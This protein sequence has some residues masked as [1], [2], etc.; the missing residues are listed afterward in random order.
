M[1]ST[2][3]TVLFIAAPAAFLISG[4]ILHFKF[5]KTILDAGSRWSYDRARL[6]EQLREYRDIMKKNNLSL[7]WY[8]LYYSVWIIV[9]MLFAVLLFAIVSG[10]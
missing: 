5:R 8:Y 6:S 4:L 7:K 2:L 3:N 9:F 1:A 10:S